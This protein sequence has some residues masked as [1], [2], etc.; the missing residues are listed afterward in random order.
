MGIRER[1]GEQLQQKNDGHI[2]SNYMLD[3]SK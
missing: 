1:D 2:C 3:F